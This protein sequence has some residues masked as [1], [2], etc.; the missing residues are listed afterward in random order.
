[1]ARQKK[2]NTLQSQGAQLVMQNLVLR[3]SR[4]ESADIA[5][6][7]TA[8]NNAKTGN[9]TKLYDLYDNILADPILS[10]AVDKRVNAITNAEIAFLRNG[11]N[12]EEID[13]LIDTP[14]F[15]ELI[16]EIVLSKGWG[17]S[18][19]EVMF[20]PE[21]NI[22]SF[23][24]KHI[25]IANLDKKLA[26]RKRYIIA[27]ESDLTGYDY[28]E[29]EYIIEC[30]K[31]D[32][33]GFLFKAAPYVIY[34][35]GG[36]GDWAEFVE[37]FGMPF[38]IG[39]YPGYDPKAKE[40]LFEALSEIGSRPRAAIPK[41][42]ELDVKENKS[43]G[44]NNLFQSFRVA[45]NEEILISVLGNTM[46]TLSG[47]SRSQAE[48]H[49]DT[50]E[51][52]SDADR[53]YVQRILNRRLVPLLLKRGYDV[54]GGFFS[55][56]DKGENLSTKDRIDIALKIK[57]DAKVPVSDDYFYE[58]S[59]IPKSEAGKPKSDPDP[60]DP[61]PPEPP[62]KK[63]LKSF[64][65]G[66]PAVKSGAKQPGFI[67]RSIWNITGNVKF[68]DGYSINVSK[69]VD[70]ALR[71]IYGGDY[72]QLVNARLWDISNNTLQHALTVEF[73]KE[74]ADWGETNKEFINEFRT[75]AAVFS[76]FKNHQ[77]T[78]DI[79]GLLID[80]KGE[81]RSFSKFKKLALQ[82][83]EK[84]NVN[85]LQT[86][87]NTAVR[88]AR[89]AI[90][91]RK[92]LAN[93][94]VYPNLEY[95]ES[96]ASDKRADHLEYVGTIL[97][98]RHEWWKIHLPP[99]AWNC[100]CGVKPTNKDVTGVPDEGEP[101]NPVFANNPGETAKM[102][103]TEETA[104]YKNTAEEIRKQVAEFGKRAEEIRQ[105]LEELKSKRKTFKSGGYI[106]IP[107]KG[108]NKNEEKK[109]IKAYSHLAS[110]YGEK[111][112]L[113]TPDKA[114]KNPDA[115]NL[116]TMVYSDVKVVET[117]SDKSAVQNSIKSASKQNATEAIIYFNRP[118][119][120]FGEIRKGLK[121]ALQKGRAKSVKYII[122]VDSDGIRRYETDRLRK[123]FK[124]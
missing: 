83:S 119:E 12:V 7:K 68:D 46:T 45:C 101:V 81:L 4:V 95:I 18:V 110:A 27:K 97:P 51:G 35:R 113:V 26:E 38:L 16:R 121:A 39:K 86:E 29:D 64:F 117:L 19:V 84:Y 116:K 34:K 106:D 22:F 66:A 78:N 75:N 123:I 1:M 37:V 5:T 6:W 47:S 53:R 62:K 36:F 10:D 93:E 74:D 105:R 88:S 23:P 122:I 33:L 11:E 80:E 43:S 72:Q 59:G 55:F 100:Q 71:E 21:F 30:G 44:S 92:Y 57:N 79:V 60:A 124:L 115:V 107:E 50:Q 13:D 9:R 99:S 40:M 32:D 31:D 52:I 111:Y 104:Y 82:I 108:Q 24:R 94:K 103:N 76:A 63:G 2:E 73:D 8:V 69:L 58:I 89:A 25:K 15:E 90:N 98:I 20:S 54:A 65:A 48:V 109:N 49:Q 17:K 112:A 42:T 102:V 96:I 14:E 77:Q 120:S 118:V 91:F 41:E 70:E 3:P 67:Q 87:Y 114:G 85:W 28:S 61:D 56:P